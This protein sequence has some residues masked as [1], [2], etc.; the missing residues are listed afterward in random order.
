MVSIPME[1]LEP[2]QSDKIQ[3]CSV[4]TRIH[5]CRTGHH[6]TSDRRVDVSE[7]RGFHQVSIFVSYT[8]T[9]CVFLLVTELPFPPNPELSIPS[10]SLV[11]HGNT[12]LSDFTPT[13]NC[14]QQF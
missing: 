5:E 11:P 4:F 8:F 2:L 13:H 6:R 10:A 14:L 12:M 7:H 1:L 9:L 3:R